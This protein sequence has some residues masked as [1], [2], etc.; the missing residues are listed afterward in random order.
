VGVLLLLVLLLLLPL[1]VTDGERV[2]GLGDL[3]VGGMGISEG[4]VLLYTLAGGKDNMQGGRG[5][6]Y[7]PMCWG[8]GQGGG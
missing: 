5:G 2:L 6:G 8:G 7:H 1:Q 4:K 3:G